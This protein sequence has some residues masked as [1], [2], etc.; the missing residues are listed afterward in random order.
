MHA[1]GWTRRHALGTG[2]AAAVVGAT[3]RA[4]L[5]QA[6]LK[7][8]FIYVGPVGDHGW[9]YRHKV[10]RKEMEAALGGKLTSTFVESVSEGPDAERVIRQLATTGHGL[11]FTTS[12]GF[13]NSTAKVARQFPM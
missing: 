10:G 1:S 3:G 6:P 8:G 9:S 5:A 11:I 7:V 2:A 12:F 4:G 13:M